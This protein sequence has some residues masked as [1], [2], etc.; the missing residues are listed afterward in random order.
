MLGARV[1]HSGHDQRD[2]YQDD[3]V[4]LGGR[5]LGEHPFQL[6]HEIIQEAEISIQHCEL[7][8]TDQ[9][10]EEDQQHSAGDFHFMQVH[11]KARVK[12]QKTLDAE[13][14]NKKW[15][16]QSQRINREQE[17]PFAHRTLRRGERE[18]GGEDRP[19]AGRPAESE[20]KAD[21]ECPGDGFAL[22]RLVDAGV[23]IE[24]LDLQQAGEVQ[25][26]EDDDRAGDDA[27][28]VT[29]VLGDLPDLGGAAPSA[30]NTTL[31]PRMK[32][33]DFTMM[34]AS[35]LRSLSCCSSSMVAPEINET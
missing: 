5:H 22:Y 1:D 13:R 7:V 29:I 4:L 2:H 27:E 25:S 11:A 10:A 32:L 6:D 31:K 35:S 9:Q 26:E 24:I 3:A 17:N 14:R 12:S 15:Y 20:G 30:M 33:I 28:D 21:G 34:P 23:R 19:D 8:E 16:R 18:D